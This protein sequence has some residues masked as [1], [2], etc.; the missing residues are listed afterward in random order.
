MTEN[1]DEVILGGQVYY[2]TLTAISQDGR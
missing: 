1:Q 2:I